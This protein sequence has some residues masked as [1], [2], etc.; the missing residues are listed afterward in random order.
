MIVDLRKTKQPA[1]CGGVASHCDT[2]KD[3]PDWDKINLSRKYGRRHIPRGE[4]AL[5]IQESNK[6]YCICMAH[7]QEFIEFH[8][9]Q[10][11]AVAKQ[12][13]EIEE[14]NACCGNNNF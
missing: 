2:Y 8:L 6:S 11:Q 9:E 13:Q 3:H 5:F 12:L 7:A 10:F 14:E 1:T 4:W